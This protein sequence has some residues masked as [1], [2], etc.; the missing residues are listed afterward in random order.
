[1]AGIVANLYVIFFGY[2]MAF[3]YFARSILSLTSM[4]LAKLELLL[5]SLKCIV[6]LHFPALNVWIFVIAAMMSFVS[7]LADFIIGFLKNDLKF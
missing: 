2:N 4:L 3:N 6:S 1:M 7:L 5:K